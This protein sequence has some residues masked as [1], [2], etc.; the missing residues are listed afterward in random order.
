[1]EIPSLEA[2]EMTPIDPRSAS[3]GSITRASSIPA[4]ARRRPR[5]REQGGAGGPQP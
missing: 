5:A 1:V 4:S 2:A 3:S